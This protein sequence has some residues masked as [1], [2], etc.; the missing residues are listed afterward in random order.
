M[1]VFYFEGVDGV[2]KT[3][4]MKAVAEL[5]IRLGEEVVLTKE[6]GGPKALFEEW[7][8]DAPY[9]EFYPGFRPLCV[10]N[11]TI[12]Q[13][14]KRALYRADSLYNWEVVV[15][16]NR[17]KIVLCDRGWMSDLAYGSV[18]T[19]FSIDRLYAFNE[20]LAPEQIKESYCV[21]L[22][23]DPEIREARLSTNVADHMDTLGAE[24]RTKID[25]AYHTVFKQ[26]LTEDRLKLVDTNK[27]IVEVVEEVVEFILNVN[28]KP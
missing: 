15:S 12:P 9:G 28:R 2:G 22:F 13:V 23:C 10:D 5:L 8:C 24:V 7:G 21:Y 3:S 27:S 16:T 26:Y 17:D 1:A 14:V 4:T 18:L 19:K 6:P 25:E 11:P 20:S